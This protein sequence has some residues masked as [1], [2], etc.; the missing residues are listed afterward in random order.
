[1]VR[2]Q[3]SEKCRKWNPCTY[4]SA[5]AS[6]K[7]S[8]MSIPTYNLLADSTELPVP[9]SALSPTSSPCP[10][11]QYHFRPF[12]ALSPKARTPASPIMPMVPPAARQESPQHMPAA[13]CTERGYEWQLL[14]KSSCHHVKPVQC[15]HECI[16]YRH[17]TYSTCL[18]PA[19]IWLVK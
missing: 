12:S 6:E 9:N 7:M 13:N 16:H 18:I 19:A 3:I 5:R 11:S 10:S 15:L 14:N 17:Y 1:M 4:Y 2:K 8:I